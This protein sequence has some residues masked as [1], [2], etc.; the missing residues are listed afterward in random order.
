MVAKGAISSSKARRSSGRPSHDRRSRQS[1]TTH[2][3]AHPAEGGDRQMASCMMRAYSPAGGASR[4]RS[5]G[6][7]AIAWIAAGDHAHVEDG[8][9]DVPGVALR[10]QSGHGILS[11]LALTMALSKEERDLGSTPHRADEE[12]RSRVLARRCP[13]SASAEERTE[14]QS[15]DRD[16]RRPPGNSRRGRRAAAGLFMRYLPSIAA[17][18]PSSKAVRQALVPGGAMPEARGRAGRAGS[19][20]AP[21]RRRSRRRPRSAWIRQV[22]SRTSP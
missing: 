5:K 12:Q 6:P 3:V 16:R 7:R 11:L 9:D 1:T 4:A 13:S 15:D 8:D 14:P 2:Q 20:R 17:G 19:R 22:A 21:G 10:R 18:V